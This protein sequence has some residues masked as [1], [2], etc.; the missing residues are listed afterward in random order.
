MGCLPSADGQ[1]GWIHFFRLCSQSGY[2]RGKYEKPDGPNR[3]KGWPRGW[4][5][6]RVFPGCPILPLRDTRS[7]KH[8]PNPNGRGKRLCGKILRGY[9][10]CQTI[11]APSY[12]GI[13]PVHSCWKL[14]R[15][16][17]LSEGRNWKN[18]LSGETGLKKA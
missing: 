8:Y 3:H 16:Y 13:V 4:C 17:P 6:L 7:G 18:E 1:R 2:R 11:P 15:Q 14:R 9:S 12:T 10:R 5:F